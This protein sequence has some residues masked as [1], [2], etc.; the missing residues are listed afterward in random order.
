[1]KYAGNVKALKNVQEANTDFTSLYF[2]FIM[3]QTVSYSSTSLVVSL[4]LL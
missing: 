1:M 3:A 4:Y 2:C